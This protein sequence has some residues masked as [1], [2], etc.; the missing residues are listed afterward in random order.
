MFTVGV[1]VAVNTILFIFN[2]EINPTVSWGCFLGWG[3]GVISIFIFKIQPLYKQLE[4]QRIKV[5]SL[6]EKS[7]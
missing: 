1:Y 7:G 4:A 2:I 6:A 5:E 3:A